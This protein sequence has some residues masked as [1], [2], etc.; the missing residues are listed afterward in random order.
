MVELGAQFG[1][2]NGTLVRPYVKAGAT[3]FDDPDFALLAS[4]E[5]A[6]S[7]VGPFRIAA[8]TDDV[9]G[10]VGAGLDVLGVDGTSFRLYYEGRFGDTVEQHAAGIKGSW[11]F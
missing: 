2:P 5:G 10:N 7:G 1:N 6:P 9:V 4:F 8:N 11:P 3:M